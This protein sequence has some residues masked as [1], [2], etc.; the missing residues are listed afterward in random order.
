[1]AGDGDDDEGATAVEGDAPPPSDGADDDGADAAGAMDA[2]G[3]A[4]P[5]SDGADDDGAGP[6]DGERADG[7]GVGAGSR[8]V[9]VAAVLAAAYVLGVTV[10]RLLLVTDGSAF[11]D[12]RARLDGVVGR[13]A[14]AV[15]VVGVLFHALDG[16]RRLAGRT[17]AQDRRLAAA[18]AFLTWALGLPIA[19]VVLWPA[20][21]ELVR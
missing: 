2:E 16:L 3:D 9:G 1:M 5:P 14:L 11:L 10:D 12:W 18:A 17:A 21:Q 15:V 8:R 4:P 6:D 13:A 7:P 20:V 19:L